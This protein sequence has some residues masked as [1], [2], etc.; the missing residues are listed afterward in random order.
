MNLGH[1]VQHVHQLP[2]AIDLFLAPQSKS[3]DADGVV[4][5]AEDRLDDSKTHAIDVAALG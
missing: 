2:L 4:D 1:I 5:V 3:F